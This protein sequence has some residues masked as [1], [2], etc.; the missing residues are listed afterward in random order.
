[1]PSPPIDARS[2]AHVTLDGRRLTVFG[3]CDY[4]ALSR[5][6]AVL[7][8]AR[9]GIERFGLSVTASRETSG[10]TSA[11][12]R[13]E[14]AA[15]AFFSSALPGADALL[16]PDG[17]TA[18]LAVFQALAALGRRVAILDERTHQSVA[19]GAVLGDL[20]VLRAPHLDAEAALDLARV[21]AADGPV[22][23]TDGVFAASGAEAPVSRL[24][25]GLPS[26]AV[27]LV[28]D[29]HG[30]AARGPR[31]RGSLE[32]LGADPSRVILT[33]T[34]AKGMGVAGGLV[35]A[36][37]GV[38]AAARAHAS[39]YIC[40]TPIAPAL[41]LA[42][43]AAMDEIDRDPARLH[44]LRQNAAA[45][46]AAVGVT[47]C[48]PDPPA[49]AAFTLGDAGAMQALREA[50]ADDAMVVPLIRYPGGPAPL[51]FRAAV[52]A[53]HTPED[54]DRL[55]THLAGARASAVVMP[56]ASMEA[57]P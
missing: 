36:S 54:M 51:Y 30:V 19:D 39:A 4:L 17:Y 46:H 29:C 14:R 41:A 9:A 23:A 5:A 34:L 49:I 10:N 56:P 32:S 40:T 3:G 26:E 8:A 25:R 12:E 55:A 1:M 57:A 15:R 20:R 38:T 2:P 27:L 24:L 31:G 45:L 7:D 37:P 33:T 13:L 47:P 11:H 48:R 52:N 6:P 22:I 16:L 35:V 50:L 21:H 43:A 42:A 18:N 44:R 28:D 53:D